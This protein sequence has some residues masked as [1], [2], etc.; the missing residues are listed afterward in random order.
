[1]ILKANQQN[2]CGCEKHAAPQ[3]L[4]DKLIGRKH[5]AVRIPARATPQSKQLKVSSTFRPVSLSK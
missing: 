2:L 5:A 3:Q 1:M 4:Y